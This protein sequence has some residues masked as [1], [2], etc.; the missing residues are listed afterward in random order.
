MSD[1]AT[2]RQH[3][4]LAV[5]LSAGLLLNTYGMGFGLPHRWIVDETVAAAL[6]VG[7]ERSLIWGDIRQ[8][9]FQTYVMTVALAPYA[10]YVQATHP[11]FEAIRSAAAVSWTEL[12]R[13]APGF[14]T[15]VTLIG[16]FVSA[17]IGVATAFV[18]YLLG[19][20]LFGVRAGLMAAAFL[21]FSQG[22]VG[23]NHLARSEPLVGFFGALVL[24][25]LVRALEPGAAQRR[26][27]LTASFFAGLA[28]A[29]K[30]NGLILVGSVGLTWL[31]LAWQDARAGLPSNTTRRLVAVAHWRWVPASAGLF[32]AGVLFG[33]PTL[34]DFLANI[35][36]V[37]AYWGLYFAE[38]SATTSFSA[39]LVN[40]IL[41]LVVIVGVPFGVFLA[42]GI[43]LFVAG[44]HATS[45]RL[46]GWLLLVT[47]TVYLLTVCRYPFPQPW[48][49]FI[50]FDV[51]LLA[52]FGGLSLAAFAG[53]RRVPAAVRIGVLVAT[54]GYSATYAVQLD[55]QLA[56]GDP[57]YATT[58]WIE[59]NMP[60]GS[61]LEHFQEEAWL[62]SARILSSHPVIYV[63]RDS[64][65][66]D[67]SLYRQ[68]EFD[69][70]E[71]E[72]NEYL[73]RIIDEG[74]SGDY[75]A[76]WIDDLAELDP[77]LRVPSSHPNATALRLMLDERLGYRL[78][79]SVRA[80]NF[81]VPSTRFPSIYYPYSFWWNPVI[82]Y[83]PV[84]I[85]LYERVRQSDDGG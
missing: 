34:L 24:Y 8:T 59:Q 85:R 84:E 35:G 56:V 76:I 74:P 58:E 12:A 14:A 3:A 10:L 17:V 62:Y 9:H 38:S 28:F 48:V 31:M 5:I 61:S 54:F 16:R 42:A 43:G 22:F 33:Q 21:V 49:K 53:A 60:P 26:M 32:T 15:N 23:S 6:R 47:A 36:D 11:D 57:R 1:V 40:Y 50:I 30:F 7:A 73:T 75:F 68:G 51:P 83:T 39:N 25:Q 69:E 20:R 66:W 13:V 37:G 71:R 52:V 79:F 82:D 67:G 65:T 29:T 70:W 2:R 19:R 18:V 46:G 55:H 80:P 72:Q 41:Q 63:G 4:L 64:R 77:A 81:K 78:V 27:F 44:R 45:V